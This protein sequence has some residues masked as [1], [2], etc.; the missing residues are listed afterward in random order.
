MAGFQRLIAFQRGSHHVSCLIRPFANCLASYHVNLLASPTNCLASYHANLLAILRPCTVS[1]W[2]N[3]WYTE[4][5]YGSWILPV[6]LDTSWQRQYIFTSQMVDVHNTEVS[7]HIQQRAGIMCK[8][9]STRC[10]GMPLTYQGLEQPFPFLWESYPNLHEF[11][12][13]PSKDASFSVGTTS[14]HIPF[15]GV[16]CNETNVEN[17]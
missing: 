14:C 3:W 7:K 17:L 5:I 15:I 2:A 1:T 12:N 6:I 16:T 13:I 11:K 4:N 8:T 10:H 9:Y